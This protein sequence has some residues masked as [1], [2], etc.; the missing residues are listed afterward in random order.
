M[1]FLTV[2]IPG[3]FAVF[4]ALL[5]WKLTNQKEKYKFKQELRL[6]EFKEKEEFYISLLSGES[7]R[8]GF[9]G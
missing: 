6:R 8:R 9:V 1:S 7:Q 4:I 5:T 3:V 2:L